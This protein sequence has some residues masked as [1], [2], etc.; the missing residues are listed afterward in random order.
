LV[1]ALTLVSAPQ[2]VASAGS[3]ASN[4]P[5]T[6]GPLVGLVTQCP[7]NGPAARN[8]AKGQSCAWSYQ[9]APAESNA[10]E[11]FSAFWIQMEIDPGAGWCAK[12][13]RFSISAP[14]DGRIVSGVPSEGGRITKARPEV[15]EL[16]V[17][18]EGTAPLPGLIS[19]DVYVPEGRT[20]V[21]VNGK[22][23]SYAWRG[24]SREKIV[25][26]IGVQMAHGRVPPDFFY[27]IS[28]SE[29]GSVGSC[30]RYLV[31]IDAR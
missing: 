6:S 9:L 3:D 12:E 20:K 7:D 29:G 25:V 24:D 14:S 1:I 5:R 16:V 26:A 8:E 23:Y 13:I 30:G 27:T 15:T 31:R 18:G 11:D 21:S 22:R 19:Q 2:V 17:D 10:T 28:E 4:N